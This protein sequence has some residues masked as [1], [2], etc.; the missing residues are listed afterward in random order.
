ML[1]RT[2]ETRPRED[3]I[4][5]MMANRPRSNDI[6]STEAYFDSTWITG[7]GT[8]YAPLD[9]FTMLFSYRG[10]LQSAD[11]VPSG[12]PWPD[13]TLLARLG[14]HYNLAQAPELRPL[15]RT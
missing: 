6:I 2:I 3:N 5:L 8:E 9:S 14:R 1:A 4:L 13:G 10:Y 15:A 7:S 12:S 11:I